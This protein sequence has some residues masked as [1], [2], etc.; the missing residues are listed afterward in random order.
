MGRSS[1]RSWRV[2]LDTR[3]WDDDWFL[4]LPDDK[5]RLAFLHLCSSPNINQAGIFE[6]SAITFAARLGTHRKRAL[7]ILQRLE[8]DGKITRQNSYVLVHNFTLYQQYTGRAKLGV[9]YDLENVFSAAPKLVQAWHVLYPRYNADT[10]PMPS[11]SLQEQEQ[12]HGPYGHRPDAG[13]PARKKPQRSK[14]ATYPQEYFDLAEKFIT[15]TVESH[16]KAKGYAVTKSQARSAPTIAAGMHESGLS[17]ADLRLTINW[18]AND[19]HQCATL[20]RLAQ[21][22]TGESWTT[23]NNKRLQQQE[24]AAKH[25]EPRRPDIASIKGLPDGEV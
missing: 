4:S 19:G 18:A 7:D 2:W 3:I 11:H 17:L 14:N 10:S 16:L 6:L 1:N 25:D 23:L 24:I 20:V 13:K 9:V 15:E 5:H 8:D 22:T 12:E 21:W